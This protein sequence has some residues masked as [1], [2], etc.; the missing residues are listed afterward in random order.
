M[1]DPSQSF[2]DHSA[3]RKS[4][5]L[6]TIVIVGLLSAFVGGTLSAVG[7]VLGVPV[8]WEG[9]LVLIAGICGSISLEAL[10]QNASKVP[11]QDDFD[12][13]LGSV[14][15]NGL[16]GYV[17]FDA[18]QGNDDSSRG[19]SDP[20]NKNVYVMCTNVQAQTMEAAA[21]VPGPKPTITT[22]LRDQN[23]L[24]CKA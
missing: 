17:Q 5:V 1:P 22:N 12:N 15:F 14:E 7:V 10:P 13:S 8:F 4:I 2:S 11:S 23:L 3:Q 9:M 20:L 19:T 24:D 16:S 18:N 21:Y 6:W